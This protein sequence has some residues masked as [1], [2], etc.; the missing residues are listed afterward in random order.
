M[1]L[2]FHVSKTE[3]KIN[4]RCKK[5]NNN[6]KIDKKSL[7]QTRG[8]TLAGLGRGR[9]T[10]RRIAL[11]FRFGHHAGHTL[12]IDARILVSRPFRTTLMCAALEHTF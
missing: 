10:A 8:T 9:L 12:E 1:A 11:C 5:K 6:E 2:N 4:D 7:T 3:K